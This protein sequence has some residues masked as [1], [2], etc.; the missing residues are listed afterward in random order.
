[1]ARHEAKLTK[2]YQGPE[3]EINILIHGFRSISSLDGFYKLARQ[4]LAA[5]PRGRVY[6]LFWKSGKWSIPGVVGAIVILFSSEVAQFKHYQY[7][8]EMVGKYIKRHIG[9]IPDAKNF[10]INFIGHS[11]GAR[12]ICYALAYNDWS[13]YRIRNCILLG[14]EAENDPKLWL[15]CAQQVKGKIYNIYSKNDTEMKLLAVEQR[16][17]TSP[18]RI[19]HPLQKKIENRD[20]YTF[21]HHD[22]WHNLNYIFKQLEPGYKRSKRFNMK[23][24]CLS[25]KKLENKRN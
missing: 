7:Q 23:N 1:M 9:K 6:L 11:L 3:K 24:C 22:Y 20:Y 19:N 15:K 13:E 21:G 5:K 17:G 10:K 12:I 2:I 14:G 18:I 25:L 4:I 8:A 16:V